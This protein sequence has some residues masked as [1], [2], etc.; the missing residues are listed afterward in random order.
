MGIKSAKNF[1]HPFL[2]GFYPVLFL[3]SHNISQV[4]KGT[5]PQFFKQS[6][7]LMK[8]N[9]ATYKSVFH[10]ALLVGRIPQNSVF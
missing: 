1:I 5:H 10:L 8:K 2:F 9:G 6:H 3:Y 7:I 4:N